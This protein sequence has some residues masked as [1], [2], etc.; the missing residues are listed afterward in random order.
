MGVS[1]AT[2]GITR[3]YNCRLV[4]SG[5]EVRQELVFQLRNLVFQDEFTFL[6]P[7]D[8]KLIEGRFLPN[9]C[10]RQIQVS[11]LGFHFFDLASDFVAS[12]HS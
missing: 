2:T 3:L 7:L 6:Q 12:I 8:V 11:M 9:A 5:N 10:N 1:R 4:A